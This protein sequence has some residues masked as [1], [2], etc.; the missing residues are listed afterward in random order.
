MVTTIL[1]SAA[2]LMLIGIV[3]LVIMRGRGKPIPSGSE[4][5]QRISR[6]NSHGT[7]RASGGD[8]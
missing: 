5:A 7:V 1:I 3:M 4:D 2:V 8:D 6:P